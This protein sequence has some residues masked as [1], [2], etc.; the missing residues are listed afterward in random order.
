SLNDFVIS[1]VNKQKNST[2]ELKIYIITTISEAKKRLLLYSL[3]KG[4]LKSCLMNHNKIKHEIDIFEKE[5]VKNIVYNGMQTG[6]FSK[7]YEPYLDH[8]AYYVINF[9]RGIIL[10]LI[11]DEE[12]NTHL[13]DDDIF[14][15]L[16]DIM[17]KGLK[18]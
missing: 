4:E 11:L 5:V 9:T 12:S 13:K 15:V 18:D 1:E 7:K 2:D 3:L 10:Q 6:E 8:I 16:I 14:N 17:I